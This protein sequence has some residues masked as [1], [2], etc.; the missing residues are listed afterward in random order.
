MFTGRN[1][2]KAKTGLLSRPEVLNITDPSL[3]DTRSPS[4]ADLDSAEKQDLQK[5]SQTAFSRVKG[6]TFSTADLS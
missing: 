5:G 3:C 1:E 6:F 2:R 4:Q